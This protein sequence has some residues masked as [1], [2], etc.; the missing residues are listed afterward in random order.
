MH[1]KQ[2]SVHLFFKSH[3]ALWR[4]KFMLTKIQMQKKQACLKEHTESRKKDS[5]QKEDI[6][7][8]D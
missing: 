1:L 7:P 3:I 6:D 4:E 8:G 2:F 5:K